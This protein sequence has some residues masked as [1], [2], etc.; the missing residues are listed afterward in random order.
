M[1]AW[2]EVRER[3]MEWVSPKTGSLGMTEC[4]GGATSESAAPPLGAM[5]NVKSCGADLRRT[6]SAGGVV[7]RFF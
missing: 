4:G 6:A 7:T 2:P 5:V 3:R 1:P